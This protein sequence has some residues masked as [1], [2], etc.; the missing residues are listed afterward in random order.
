MVLKIPDG[1]ARGDIADDG[2]QIQKML[3][4]QEA[5]GMDRAVQG[6]PTADINRF[7][8]SGGAAYAGILPTLTQVSGLSSLPVAVYDSPKRLERKYGA[9][10][11]SGDQEFL[12]YLPDGVTVLSTDIIVYDGDDYRVVPG[13]SVFY[14][15][16]SGRNAVLS[17]LDR[18]GS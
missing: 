15:A 3:Q 8:E 17:R 16:D 14:E 18:P 7:T 11:K 1:T 4:E 2:Y 10:W 9:I 6:N 13:G 5:W 12:F